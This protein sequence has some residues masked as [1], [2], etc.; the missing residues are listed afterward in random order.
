MDSRLYNTDGASVQRNLQRSVS[1]VS[2]TTTYGEAT[3]NTSV[4]VSPTKVT[5]YKPRTYDLATGSDVPLPEGHAESSWASSMATGTGS[6]H[7]VNYVHTED[8]MV[9]IAYPLPKT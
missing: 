8:A 6:A 2:F 3:L 5:W 1:P 9:N 4:S 7:A